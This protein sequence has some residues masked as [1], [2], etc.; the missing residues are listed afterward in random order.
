MNQPVRIELPG[1][2]HRYA[3]GH[4]IRVVLAAS[5]SAYGGNLSVLPVTVKTAV[6]SVPVLTL[7]VSGDGRVG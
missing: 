3:Q 2:V 6:G 5:D 1:V 4:R 7:P